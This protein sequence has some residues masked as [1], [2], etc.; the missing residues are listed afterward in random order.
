MINILFIGD[1]VSKPGRN[2]VKELLPQL[3]KE[4]K[5]DFV[6]ANGENVTNG[7]G[8]SFDHYSELKGYG[9]DVTPD[10]IRKADTE[11]LKQRVKKEAVL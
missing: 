8:I 10:E 2:A 5:V 4:H 7:R 9:I 1:I 3:K 11:E 6:I